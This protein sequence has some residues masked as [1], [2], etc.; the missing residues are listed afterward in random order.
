[1]RIIL[2]V[3]EDIKY[4]PPIIT[5]INS[6]AELGYSLSVIGHYSD[7]VQ[8]NE[9]ERKGVDFY[10]VGAYDIKGSHINKIFQNSNFRSKVRK[11]V[12]GI[13]PADEDY[14]I[15]IIQSNTIGLLNKLVDSHPVI[16]HPL[17]F[18][19]KRVGRGYRLLSPR[20]NVE[21]TY[22]K[23]RKVVNC[24]YNRAQITKGLLNLEALPFVLPNKMYVD[25]KKLQEVPDDILSLVEDIKERIRGKKV[26]LY[27]GI[28]L[29][30]ERRLE[31]FCQ[32]VDM[33]DDQYCL[34][35]M[36]PESDIYNRLKEKY[37]SDKFIFIDFIRPPYHLLVT[38]L[39]HIGILTYFPRS[40]NI[41]TVINPLYCAP[42][43]I[44]EY[45]KFGVPMISNDIP[46]LHY[47]FQEFGCGLGVKYPM[48]PELIV[49][50]IKEIFSD[51]DR[52]SKG[53]IDYFNSVDVKKIIKEI[54]E[55]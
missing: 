25:E 44:F 10:D 53:A 12:R 19:G 16:L 38:Q 45:G 30:K 41:T 21:K 50:A 27:Q 35:A 32:A 31:E 28:F 14:Y 7:M 23:A 26:I 4:F 22:Q 6:I 15:W 39:A 42:N 20:Y 51:Y 52:Y 48:T 13:V 1:M 36:G 2:I 40:L 46:G 29:D 18:T 55:S 43:K 33:L 54:I 17:E 37:E 5:I 9:M 34:I 8:K 49:E 24:E 47:I 11:I 3:K